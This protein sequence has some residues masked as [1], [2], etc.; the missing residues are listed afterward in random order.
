ME[1]NR[2]DGYMSFADQIPFKFMSYLWQNGKAD[3]GYFTI[4]VPFNSANSEVLYNAFSMSLLINN[5][6]DIYNKLV[7][8]ELIESSLVNF[9]ELGGQI[10]Y[11]TK[12]APLDNVMTELINNEYIDKILYC[13]FVISK[14]DKPAI[15]YIKHIAESL[16]FM[17]SNEIEIEIS[18]VM[19]SIFNTYRVTP[20]IIKLI[21]VPKEFIRD[22]RDYQEVVIWDIYQNYRKVMTINKVSFNEDQGVEFDEEYFGAYAIFNAESDIFIKPD[23][24][25][26]ATGYALALVLRKMG[27]SAFIYRPKIN[28]NAKFRT[29]LFL[30]ST[31]LLMLNQI[32]YL[33]GDL[34]AGNFV[35]EINPRLWYSGFIKCED[36]VIVNNIDLYINFDLIDFGSCVNFHDSKSLIEFVKMVVP[37]IYGN[38][39]E[40]IEMIANASPQDLAIAAT[41]L[42]LHYFIESFFTINTEYEQIR[43]TRDKFQLYIV[44]EFTKYLESNK[45]VFD[46]GGFVGG[47][48]TPNIQSALSIGGMKKDKFNFNLGGAD[49]L[50]DDIPIAAQKQQNFNLTTRLLPLFKL[51]KHFYMEESK[52]IDKE[53]IMNV[54]T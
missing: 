2:I 13:I 44:E 37:N 1:F 42:D 34:H 54:I 22:V 8:D 16:T 24:R 43:D 15:F 49:L 21:P 38:Y 28:T 31:R 35:L 18:R 10:T 19:Y 4:G 36:I 47:S 12:G 27:N 39:K 40:T 23:I 11:N 46:K 33:H 32:S 30:V 7:S 48:M 5:H 29:L 51:L 53:K 50:E 17:P 14:F 3:N 9:Y 41:L 26:K 6:T 25:E 45:N 20:Y 52:M